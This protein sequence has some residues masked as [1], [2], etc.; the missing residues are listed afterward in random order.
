VL[1]PAVSFRSE[2]LLHPRTLTNVP[3]VV[4]VKAV[5]I[6]RRRLKE[7]KTYEDFRKA[8]YHTVGFGTASTLYTVINA[9]DPKEIIVIGFVE[10]DA[11]QDVRSILRIDVKE[12]LENPL[13]AVIEPVIGREFGLLVSED[14]FSTAG[15]LEYKAPSIRGKETNLTE[16]AQGLSEA[17]KLIAEAS[18]ERDS[19][20]KAGSRASSQNNL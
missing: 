8:W 10:V 9:F 18:A 19:A 12:R 1:P 5:S 16:I 7:G 4:S 13:D 11:G 14:D 15:A 6:I 2:P 3:L 17:R 20:K